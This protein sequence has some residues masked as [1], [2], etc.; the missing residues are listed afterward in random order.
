MA[1]AR[2]GRMSGQTLID[3]SPYLLD[4]FCKFFNIGLKEPHKFFRGVAY[5]LGSLNE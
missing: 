3:T 5:G 1:L 4:Q 2:Q